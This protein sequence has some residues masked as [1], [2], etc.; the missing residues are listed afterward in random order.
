MVNAYTHGAL[1]P[2][3]IALSF[4]F[5]VLAMIV[6]LG[7]ISGAHINPAVTLA[8]WSVRRFP[9][10]EVVPYLL[11]QCVG[12]LAASAVLRFV[13]GPIGDLGATLPHIGVRGA[14]LVEWIFSFWPWDCRRRSR[15]GWDCSW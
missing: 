7:H 11:A 15:R 6:A 13:L 1:G 14:F 5:V 10:R 2:T 12:A 8:F 9:T 3:G 4:G